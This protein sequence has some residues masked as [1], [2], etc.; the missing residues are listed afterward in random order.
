MV[1]RTA[2]FVGSSHVGRANAGNGHPVDVVEL[3]GLELVEPLVHGVLVAAMHW[4]IF[5]NGY[6]PEVGLRAANGN[7]TGVSNPV[8]A[9]DT[10]RFKTVIH[11][12][13][14]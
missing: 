8:Y 9:T 4:C 5:V 12:Q 6:I 14:V 3:L 1:C 13:D 11:A 10:S 2:N 7:G